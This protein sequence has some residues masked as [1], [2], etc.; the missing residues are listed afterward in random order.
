MSTLAVAPK[1]NVARLVEIADFVE[2][3]CLRRRDLSVSVVDIVRILGRQ[4]DASE[5]ETIAQV[6]TEAFQ[7]LDSRAI[8]CGH[9][10]R[11]Y[12]FSLDGGGTLLRCKAA[13]VLV[14][15]SRE[16]Y[17]FLLLATRMNMK[18]ERVQAGEDATVL[19]EH[20]C[21]FVA[22]RYW[23]GPDDDIGAYVF[24]TGRLVEDR[25]DSEPLDASKFAT[26]VNELCKRLGEGISF[27]AH[28][29][30][31]VT[32][33][34]G[35]LDIVVWRRFADSRGGQLIGFGQCKTGTNWQRDLHKLVP[36]GFCEKWMLK[37]PAVHPVR[38]YF[39]A[40]R[41]VVNWYDKNKDGG[42]IFDRCRLMQFS[43]DVPREL[44]S[45]IRKWTAAGMKVHGLSFR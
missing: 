10:G 40:D 4:S 31:V 38:L 30:S 18:T 39:V 36:P 3:E 16:I 8:H 35:K 15:S 45:A 27:Q 11:R 5:E 1:V 25:D 12:P 33:K 14:P 21:G 29:N 37:T 43:D 7:E 2:L 42:I 26:A 32:A 19:F 9:R 23:G 24:G 17:L 13:K 34:D 6:V 41:I 22:S 20:L 28:P 44:V